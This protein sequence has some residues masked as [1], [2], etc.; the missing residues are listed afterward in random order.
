MDRQRILKEAQQIAKKFS[1]WMVSGNIAHL[2]GYAYETPERKFELEIKFD[3][4]FPNSPPQMIYTNEIKELLGGFKLDSL[5]NWLPE[6]A[7]VEIVRE[8][9]AKI[10]NKLIA[11]GRVLEN[12]TPTPRGFRSK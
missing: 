11:I 7:V 12:Q 9:R 4:T 1:F 3:D 8:L 6:R 5:T 10:V 2:Y